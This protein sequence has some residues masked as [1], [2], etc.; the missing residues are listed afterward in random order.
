[1]KKT[2]YNI[3]EDGKVKTFQTE[4]NLNAHHKDGIKQDALAVVNF[5]SNEYFGLNERFGQT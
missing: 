4:I 3:T 5:R 2:G 1:M